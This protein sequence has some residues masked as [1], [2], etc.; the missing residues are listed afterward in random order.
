MLY[1]VYFVIIQRYLMLHNFLKYRCR[2][3]I[4]TGEGLPLKAV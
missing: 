4:D 1:F 3:N 2:N